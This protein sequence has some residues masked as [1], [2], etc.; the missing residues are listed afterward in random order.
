[1]TASQLYL[2]YCQQLGDSSFGSDNEKYF[3]IVMELGEYALDCSD[4]K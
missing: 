4:K 2:N 3:F 1:M